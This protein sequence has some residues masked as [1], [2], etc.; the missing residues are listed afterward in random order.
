M[1]PNTTAL[2][3]VG[4]QNDYFAS[5]GILRGVVEEANRWV[6]SVRYA[7]LIQENGEAAQSVDEIWHLVKPLD[8]SRDW[9]IAG[10]T[11]LQS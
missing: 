3:L 1:D 4:Y 10:I 8:D 5:N 2:I 11:P 7:A 9:A 6:V